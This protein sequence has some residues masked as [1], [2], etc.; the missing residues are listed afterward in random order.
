MQSQHANKHTCTAHAHAH[1]HAHAQVL[2]LPEGL[3]LEVPLDQHNR[4]LSIHHI[5]YGRVPAGGVRHEAPMRAAQR[6]AVA[7]HE[8]AC[9]TNAR[10][11]IK[12]T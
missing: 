11:Q 10:D 6:S 3:A 12:G 5:W 9:G 4:P 2:L 1:A 7:Q 8:E